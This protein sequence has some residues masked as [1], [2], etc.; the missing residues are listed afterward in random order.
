M[1]FSERQSPWQH[2]CQILHLFHKVNALA[3]K[4][5]NLLHYSI[6]KFEF[7]QNMA[8]DVRDKPSQI[9]IENSVHVGHKIKV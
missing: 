2:L 7:G 5:L 8:N 4:G 3:K 6:F 9:E 1:V